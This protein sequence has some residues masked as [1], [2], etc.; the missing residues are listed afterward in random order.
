MQRLFESLRNGIIAGHYLLGTEASLEYLAECRYYIQKILEI[1]FN[2]PKNELF[3]KRREDILITP[4]D[5]R[6]K[7]VLDISNIC[8]KMNSEEYPYPMKELFRNDEIC[9][10]IHHD[11]ID[12]SFLYWEKSDDFIESIEPNGNLNSNKLLYRCVLHADHNNHNDIINKLDPNNLKYTYWLL[13][14][15]CMYYRGSASITEMYI[16]VM[17]NKILCNGYGLD[18][19]AICMSYEEFDKKFDLKFKDNDAKK[20]TLDDLKTQY[21]ELTASRPMGDILLEEFNI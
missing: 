18:V 4:M 19:H 21:L 2:L 12:M 17:A 8:H 10:K 15:S 14:Q 6:Y 16:S 5:G 7:N 11:G 20:I 3:G 9:M 1:S 13:C